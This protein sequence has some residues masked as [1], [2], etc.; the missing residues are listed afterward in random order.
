MPSLV[1][2]HCFYFTQ[3]LQN[4]LTKANEE[5]DKAQKKLEH[6]GYVYAQQA[7]V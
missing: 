5:R 2:L 3:E 1:S 4:S 6:N 7:Q